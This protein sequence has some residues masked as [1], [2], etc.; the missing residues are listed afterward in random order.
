[1]QKPHYP[2][3]GA[4]LAV[5]AP[6]GP[7]RA[8]AF[9]AGLRRLQ[10]HYRLRYRDDLFARRAFLAGD[11]ARRLEELLGA[12]E[13]P[14][15]EGI[16]AARGGYGATRLLD[17]LPIET[18]ARANK[19]LVG[20]SD[21]TALHAL[22][23]KAGCVSIHAPGIES[24]HRLDEAGFDHWLD[25]LRGLPL[26]AFES[27]ALWA[28]GRFEGPIVGGNLS[29]L[30]ALSGTPHRPPLQGSILFLED[31]GESPYR[32]DRMLTNLRQ[33]GWFDEVGAI[34][35]GQFTDCERESEGCSVDEVLKERLLP[36]GL[37]MLAGFPAGHEADN[38]A[39]PLNCPVQLDAEVGSLRFLG[40]R[41]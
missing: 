24:L 40:A 16:V 11:D 38:H 1:M 37:P 34:L 32:I 23:R 2:Q 8:E 4:L 6:S 10:T 5:I 7:V 9:D 14:E 20:F 15:V 31:V 18:I 28:R 35:L 13:D 30:H 17:A 41:G 19:L 36:L 26:R 25:A 21:I 33:A 39:L 27:L 3:A 12:L 29:L 22:W